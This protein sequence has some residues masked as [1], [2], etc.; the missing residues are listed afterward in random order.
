MG[1]PLTPVRYPY[2]TSERGNDKIRLHVKF[3]SLIKKKYRFKEKKI[4][5][6]FSNVILVRIILLFNFAVILCKYVFKNEI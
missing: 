1:L 4:I 2:V 3:T 5:C 6:S